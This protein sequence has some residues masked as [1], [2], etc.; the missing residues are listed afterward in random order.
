[1]KKNMNTPD[2]KMPVPSQFGL[3]GT[4]AAVATDY[5]QALV[6][7]EMA[8]L[9]ATPAAAPGQPAT[10]VELPPQE[11]ILAI[12]EKYPRLAFYISTGPIQRFT[13]LDF[14][15]EYRRTLE[16]DIRNAALEEAA[17]CCPYLEDAN[18]I[19]ALKSEATVSAIVQP[20]KEDQICE[21][22]GVWFNDPDSGKSKWVGS[23][24]AGD[25]WSPTIFWPRERA[26]DAC[27]DPR[28]QPRRI[29]L[30]AGNIEDAGS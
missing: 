29:R 12:A 19:R 22:W 23:L 8:R 9:A 10:E 27:I 15:D 26:Q 30:V 5:G 1:M 11:P 21:L 3:T 4:H 6:A 18:K 14:C 17:Q 7:W 28:Y 20:T 2:L 25:V 24:L 16:Q 13:F